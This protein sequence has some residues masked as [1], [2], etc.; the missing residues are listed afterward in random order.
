LLV[1]IVAGPVLWW[2]SRP[3]PPVPPK[4]LIFNAVSFT[5]LAGWT[6]D[7][8]GEALAAFRLSCQ[9]WAKRKPGRRSGA[10]E[11]DITVADWRDV[12][13][14]A[15][16]TGNDD[17]A[18][19]AFFEKQFIP[20]AVTDDG[21]SQGLF[22]GYYEPL[23]KGSL[24]KA[25]DFTVPLYR[26]PEDLISADL[27]SFSEALKGR[28]LLGRV[29]GRRFLPYYS[30]AEINAGALT[31][32]DLELLYVDSIVD[33]F[34]LQ[35]QGSGRV[36][37]PDGQEIRV[38]YAGKNGRPYFAIG[39]ALIREGALPADKVSM[40]SIRRWLENHP[41]E[42]G[43]IMEENQS[44]V[45]FR[46][47]KGQSIKG[48][49]GVPLTA[50]R[51]LAIDHRLLPMGAPIWLDTTR[52]GDTAGA[53][54]QPYRR[55]MVAQDT[56]GAIRGGIR[57]DIFWGHGDIAEWRAGHSKHSGRWT[58]FVPRSVAARWGEKRVLFR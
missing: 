51:T 52:P 5:Q 38:G 57:G 50:E 19:R 44:F 32:K 47:L 24:E 12:C 30:H 23:L 54:E 46:R 25:G 36:R 45:F 6:N 40:Q 7:V 10:A 55:L 42:A 20:Y 28:H 49:L 41:D 22:T 3:P 16:S 8:Q 11:L 13:R 2:L 4:A 35:I 58:L 15:D 17:T 14:Q 9:A 26:R 39:R 1:L 34:F 21:R 53:P 56:G 31:G 18:A 29:K 27:G 33:A 48:A 43:R 37:L